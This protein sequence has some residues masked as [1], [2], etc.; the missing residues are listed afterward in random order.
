MTGQARRD[1]TLPFALLAAVLALASLL[2]FWPPYFSKFATLA[3]VRLHAHVGFVVL[4]MAA[5][6]AQPLLIRARRFEQH[7][8]VGR[9][10][11]ALAPLVVVS[12]MLLSHA[13]FS[14]A[15]A[16]DFALHARFFYLP[17]QATVGFALSY[18]LA[19]A[20]RRRRKVH[21][22]FMLG[23]ALALIDPIAARIILFYTDTADDHWIYDYIAFAISG[24]I[25]LILLALAR[26]S[27][28]RLAFAALLALFACLQI[29]WLTL[30]RT[31]LWRDFAAWFVA[32]PL[33]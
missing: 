33:S 14:A 17:V 22:A 5:L 19:I 24:P 18:A 10:S 2:A 16:E 6:I 27:P 12:A 32:L 9:L 29:G 30:S 25:L 7:R 23:T 8:L 28:A 15:P 4:W 13:R 11:F 1:G 31:T 20:F 3:D 21:A 26:S